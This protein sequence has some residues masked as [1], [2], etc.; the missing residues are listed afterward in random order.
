MPWKEILTIGI[1]FYSGFLFPILIS[2]V[3]CLLLICKKKRLFHNEVSVNQSEIQ[4]GLVS[5]IFE[6][7]LQM[8]MVAKKK[9]EEKTMLQILAAER[10]LKTNG[11]VG[12]FFAILFFVFMV[13]S[14]ES[15]VYFQVILFKIVQAAL[16]LLT[17][18]ANFGTIQHVAKNY[19]T[20]FHL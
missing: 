14:K 13:L 20:Y 15:R 2:C 1:L 18:I 16:P 4:N 5:L 10:T 8:E 9:E 7:E 11:I 6:N 12:I 17:T 3:I 19:F